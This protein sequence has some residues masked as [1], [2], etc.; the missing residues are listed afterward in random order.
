MYLCFFGVQRRWQRAWFGTKRPGVQISILR[1]YENSGFQQMKAANFLHN[2]C[3]PSNTYYA[4]SQ[5]QNY[6]CRLRRSLY[7]TSRKVAVL[8]KKCLCF[9]LIIQ[10]FRQLYFYKQNK[11]SLNDKLIYHTIA[12]LVKKQR[13]CFGSLQG[14]KTVSNDRHYLHHNI[15][16]HILILLQLKFLQRKQ[17]AQLTFLMFTAMTR[18]GI[19]IKKMILLNHNVLQI[20]KYYTISMR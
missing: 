13:A 5:N 6:S 11:I 3:F 14:S 2:N 16:T 19:Q 15:L 1:P 18:D 4:K 7:T 9:I 20:R 12:L 8:I 10:Y 17:I